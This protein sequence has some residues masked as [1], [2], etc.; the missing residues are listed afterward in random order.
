MR[1]THRQPHLF[2]ILVQSARGLLLLCPFVTA[3]D[4]FQT[5][6]PNFQ[7]I[8]DELILVLDQYIVMQSFLITIF[9]KI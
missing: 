4:A 2:A 9:F 7:A 3:K 8:P 5:V 6:C 1:K